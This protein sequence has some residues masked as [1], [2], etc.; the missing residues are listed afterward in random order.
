[1]SEMVKFGSK[2][3]ET[4]LE[5]LRAYAKS[6]G[7][8]MASLL[9]EAVEEYLGRVRIRPAFRAATDEVLDEHEE[10]LKRLAR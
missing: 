10:L 7:R 6:S 4:V 9:T 3:D 8:S 5:E 2:L 1:M